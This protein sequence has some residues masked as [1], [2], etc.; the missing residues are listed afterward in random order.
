MVLSLYRSTSNT[1]R[2]EN[3]ER[4]EILGD[5]SDRPD[6]PPYGATTGRRIFGGFVD[7]DHSYV[8]ES[9]GIPPVTMLMRRA[10]A[11]VEAALSPG[12]QPGNIGRLDLLYA[13]EVIMTMSEYEER[14]RPPAPSLHQTFAEVRGP[15]RGGRRGRRLWVTAALVGVMAI[16]SK[17]ALHHSSHAGG[18]QVSKSGIQVCDFI[19]R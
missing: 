15:H 3:D 9:R 1:S 12:Q 8:V 14:F 5:R 4:R 17:A 10:R 6:R 11:D 16:T 18:P 7:W 19:R 13:R 2:A